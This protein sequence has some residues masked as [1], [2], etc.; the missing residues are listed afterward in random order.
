VAALEELANS[1]IVVKCRIRGRSERKP[2]DRPRQFGLLGRGAL[3]PD[4]S[5][6]QADEP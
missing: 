5:P 6:I 4:E 1:G 2:A 3:R